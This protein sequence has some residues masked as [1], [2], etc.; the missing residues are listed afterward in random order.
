MANQEIPKCGITKQYLKVGEAPELIRVPDDVAVPSHIYAVLESALYNRPASLGPIEPGLYQASPG[1]VKLLKEV[2]AE[3]LRAR[4]AKQE[5]KI[6]R[7]KAAL[8]DEEIEQLTGKSTDR[9]LAECP[10]FDAERLP[11]NF[12]V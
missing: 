3:S 1:V 8:T 12:C 11:R 6:E 5:E 9:L 10:V 7:L 4:R 2:I